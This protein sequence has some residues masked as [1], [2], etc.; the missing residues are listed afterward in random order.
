MRHA[1]CDAGK[2]DAAASDCRAGDDGGAAAA[3]DCNADATVA[4]EDG[5]TIT[6]ATDEPGAA[7]SSHLDV[8]QTIGLLLELNVNSARKSKA[9]A[10]VKVPTVTTD[11]IAAAVAAAAA[12]D[13]REGRTGL[14]SAGPGAVEDPTEAPN[15]LAGLRG[16]SQ[17]TRDTTCRCV[18][19]GYTCA[20]GL[21]LG[22]AKTFECRQ[23]SMWGASSFEGHPVADMIMIAATLFEE[24]GWR[25]LKNQ[26]SLL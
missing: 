13:E 12:A 25:E 23:S 21:Q 16:V 5:G 6:T 22:R 2:G 19:C 14:R 24:H 18:S 4:A 7:G 1:S 10:K 8:E 20:F 26:D 11:V 3:D 17:A 15:E 9:A